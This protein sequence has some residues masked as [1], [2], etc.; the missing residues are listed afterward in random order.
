MADNIP[1]ALNS[2]QAVVYTVLGAEGPDRAGTPTTSLTVAG[3]FA[4]IAPK[5]GIVPTSFLALR[6]T[7]KATLERAYF[8]VRVS[9]ER[10]SALSFTE[11]S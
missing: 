11:S 6:A 1:A 8:F 3:T 5:S 2:E 9:W 4:G 10:D 7:A